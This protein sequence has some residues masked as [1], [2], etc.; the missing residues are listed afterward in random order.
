MKLINK[1]N[2][3]TLADGRFE[4]SKISNV[5]VSPK[6]TKDGNE[7]WFLFEYFGDNLVK[8]RGYDGEQLSMCAEI[9]TKDNFMNIDA[10][11]SRGMAFVADV[12]LTTAERERFFVFI[13]NCIL[14]KE[15]LEVKWDRG[16]P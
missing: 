5:W 14:G 3:R 6:A 8:K 1:E 9:T 4:L 10:T 12:Q 15:S 16:A 7:M 13:I 11:N 2:G